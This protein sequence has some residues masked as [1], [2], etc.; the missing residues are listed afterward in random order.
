MYQV[1]PFPLEKQLLCFY[2][3]LFR[4][5]CA[6]FLGIASS[7]PPPPLLLLQEISPSTKPSHTHC[8]FLPS[9]LRAAQYV[10]AS[11]EQ[12]ERER[13][14]LRKPVSRWKRRKEGRKEGFYISLFL[15]YVAV[16]EWGRVTALN[17]SSS[18]SLSPS[19]F[20]CSSKL[21]LKRAKDPEKSFLR[22]R[23]GR[24]GEALEAPLFHSLLFSSLSSPCLREMSLVTLPSLARQ[25]F[26]HEKINN[27]PHNTVDYYQE[28]NECPS[29]KMVK[30]L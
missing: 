23:R 11:G 9:F 4:E 8:S 26:R 28:G 30:L 10:K 25:S 19:S 14:L 20:H 22:W 2:S 5:S 15:F 7:P 27:R 29:H 18:S 6:F 17:T 1:L 16:T 24:E 12:R 13:L 3:V 21:G